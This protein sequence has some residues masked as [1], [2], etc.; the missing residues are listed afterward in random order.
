MTKI[1]D[2][3]YV[4]KTCNCYILVKEGHTRNLVDKIG[5][6]DN[7]LQSQLIY[8]KFVAAMYFRLYR[9]EI[10]S[11][12]LDWESFITNNLVNLD[13]LREVGMCKFKGKAYMHVPVQG[14]LSAA[15][16]RVMYQ[17]MEYGQIFEK[18]PEY[19]DPLE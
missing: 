7:N 14:V 9:V 6:F 13:L 8:K 16:K 17:I 2:L 15:F 18:F 5:Q 10:C 4:Q 12:G 19:P 3:D 1:L 11:L